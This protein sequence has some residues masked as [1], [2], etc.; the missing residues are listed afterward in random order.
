MA[1]PSNAWVAPEPV[2]GPA[3]GVYFASHGARLIAYLIDTLIQAALF[4]GLFIVSFVFAVIAPP[5]FVLGVLGGFAVSLAYYP[6]FWA[7]N[8]QTPGMSMQH[9][10]VVRDADGGPI[11]SGQAILRFVGYWV[12]GAIFYLGYIWIFIDK[13][14]RGWHDLIAG[15]VVIAVP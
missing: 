4:I 9:I 11:T 8:G 10:K 3:P 12:S 1:Q 6:F 14:R 13:R 2:S 15:T 5:L 7:R